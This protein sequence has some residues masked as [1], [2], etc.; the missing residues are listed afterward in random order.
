MT[1]EP[2]ITPRITVESERIA[3]ETAESLERL[4]ERPALPALPMERSVA[5]VRDQMA[6]L[7]E[8]MRSVMKE[9]EDFGTI[10]GTPKPSLWQPGAEKIAFMFR[11]V[12]TYELSEV[13]LDGGHLEVT[14]KCTLTHGPTGQLAGN[15]WAS[16]T[17]MEDRYRWR[18]A[19]VACPSCGK[20]SVIR[21]KAEFGGGW[22]CWQ[23]KGGCGSKWSSDSPEGK[24][25]ASAQDRV[26]NP[27]IA[28]E[29]NTVRQMAQKR[30]FLRAMRTSTAASQFFTQDVAEDP[31]DAPQRAAPESEAA[32]AAQPRTEAPAARGTVTDI[33]LTETD[34]G[35][36]IDSA[37][38]MAVLNEM[39]RNEL[40]L[41]PDGEVKDRLRA[42]WA[43]RRRWLS[44]QGGVA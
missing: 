6:K 44:Q 25:F 20:A 5:D 19:D 35:S 14:A 2:R 27:D 3:R 30:S 24:R 15:A 28:N 9:G 16:C 22:L 11:L 42:K 23:K 4:A 32:P 29:R 26:E 33:R 21:G 13:E 34:L 12:P 18:K 37:G 39:A 8:L 36:R 40:T 1:D 17:T 41:L 43:R 7:V 10:P 38:T 31:Q